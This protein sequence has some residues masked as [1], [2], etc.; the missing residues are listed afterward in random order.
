MQ[1]T[2]QARPE[3]LLRL[4]H[5][6]V[7][8]KVKGGYLSAVKDVSLTVNR[9]EIFAIVGESGCGKSTIAHTILRLLMDG[10]E[11][12]TGGIYFK[13]EKLND[14][15]EPQIEKVRGKHIGMIFQ[16]P[17]DS[18]NPVYR[19]GAQVAEAILLDNSN[20]QEVWEQVLA[21]YR[22]VRM[23]D[24]EK[25]IRSYPHELSGGMRQ[26]VMI[27]MMLSRNPELL[28][29][30]EPTTALDVTIE[31]QI[32]QI[33]SELKRAYGTSILLI[34]H[35]F[36]LVAEVADRIGVMYAGEMVEQGD[37]FEIFRNPI[38]PYTR[39]LM[40]ALPRGTKAQ[41]RLTTIDGTVPRLTEIL[42]GCRFANRCPLAKPI[43]AEQ[44]PPVCDESEGHTFRCHF[45]EEAKAW[46]L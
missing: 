13:D 42:P 19:S 29:A 8:Y 41:G 21:L 43:C 10:N 38:H 12:V 2:Q 4:D 40:K 31:A 30:D 33:L 28:I 6:G 17:L 26:R 9:G 23:P 27:A 15:S 11:R 45:G 5:L 32:L 18:L 44:D 3:S 25:R 7:E 46:T 14:M 36:G 35:N 1:T 20:R 16:N 24:A 37:V 22:D 34:T 39:L